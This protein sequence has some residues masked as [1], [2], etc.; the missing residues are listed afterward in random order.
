MAYDLYVVTDEMLSNGLSHAEIA[1]QAVAGGATVIQLRDKCMSSRAL[2]TAALD[3]REITRGKALFIV[4]DRVD[5]ALASGAD[6]VHLGQ[7][8]LPVAEARRIVPDDFVIGISVG[9]VEEAVAAEKGGA[10]YVAVSPVFSTDSKPD[11]G[12]G[13]GIEMIGGV[14]AAV[15]CPV[16]GIGG[17]NRGNVSA[18]I[19]AGLDGAAVISAVVSAPDIAAAARDMV[20][21]IH[22]AKEVRDA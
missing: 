13:H 19:A 12:E 17:I 10:D 22:D 21:I 14:R 2:F 9:S 15:S 3:I 5:I 16:L 11:A 1:R 20:G 8:D 4:N 18:L 6:G 7:D